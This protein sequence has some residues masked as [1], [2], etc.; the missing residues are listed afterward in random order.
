MHRKAKKAATAAEASN[1]FEI[2]AREW[3]AKQVPSWTEKHAIT[4]IRRLELNIFPR[5]ETL[6][7]VEISVPR[8]LAALRRMDIGKDDMTVHGFR[9]MARTILDEVLGLQPDHIEQ[10]LAHSVREPNLWAFNL[11]AHLAE[12]HQLLQ[13]WTDY[14]ENLKAT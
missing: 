6:P 2:V 7:T 3:H 10:Q 1:N 4:V 8:L 11:T 13:V 5:L 9:A 12:R 14:I